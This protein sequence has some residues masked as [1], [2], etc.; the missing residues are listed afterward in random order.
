MTRSDKLRAVAERVAAL[1]PETVSDVVLTG[2]TARGVADKLSV[3][4]S[5]VFALNR[6]WEPGWKRIAQRLQPLAI[7]TDRLAERLD[8]A[9]RALDLGALHELADEAIALA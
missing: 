9:V 2:S 8:T 1:L 4:L 6:E 7:K 3:I 5:I